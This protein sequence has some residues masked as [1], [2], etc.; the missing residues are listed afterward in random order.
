ML[1]IAQLLSESLAGSARD[2]EAEYGEQVMSA[3]WNPALEQLRAAAEGD[4]HLEPGG[5]AGRLS[6]GNA[7]S[8]GP[9]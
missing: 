2:A 4:G 3:G 1:K 8:D 6:T 5:G 9:A 7:G